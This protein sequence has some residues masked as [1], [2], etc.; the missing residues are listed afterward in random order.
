MKKSTII[1]TILA[2][3]CA[4]LLGMYANKITVHARTVSSCKRAEKLIRKKYETKRQKVKFY[5]S[6][7]LSTRRLKSRKGK[8]T[9]IVEKICGK[10]IDN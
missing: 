10:V 3:M 8:G 2:F 9:V 1:F 7:E 4:F 6:S 5:N